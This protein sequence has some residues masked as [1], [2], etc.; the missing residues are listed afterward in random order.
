MEKAGL[1]KAL[2][3]QPAPAA[4]VAELWETPKLRALFAAVPG[5][6][7]WVM[8]QQME[9]TAIA[10][11]TGLE[12]LR[13]EWMLRQFQ[14]LGLQA[15]VDE[16]GN[17]VAERAGARRGEPV[18]AVTAHLD[19]AFAP[20]TA[21]TVERRRGRVWAPGI[22]DNGAG[23]A[24]LL[25]MARLLR[26][27]HC[28]PRRGL[29]L[30][31][32]VGEEGEGDLRGMRHL[33]APGS[34]LGRRI[35]A[36]VVLDGPGD[37]QITTGALPSRRLRVVFTG[38]GGHSWSD[39]GRASATH[40]AV[41]AAGALLAQVHPRPGVLGC[42]IGVLQGGTVVNAI[43]AGAE[44]KLDLRAR[45]REGLEELGQAVRRAVASGLEQERAAALRGAVRARIE[46]LGERPGGALAAGS[47]L[48]ELVR[49][50]DAR[51]GIRS[52]QQFASTDAN[53][54]IAQGRDALRLGAGGSGGGI[55]TLGEWF[56][57]E[58][59]ARA[60]QRLLLIVLAWC[61]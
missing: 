37:D 17:V 2:A 1:S 16:A 12:G 48:L 11:P 9:V 27:A 60:L 25:A 31:A 32:T 19:T 7:A 45:S 52:R 26:D 58:G 42:N 54:P 4:E 6:E 38:P 40:A 39:L 3:V 29:L 43:A 22:A 57:P 28:R 55:H 34:K 18:L 5:L 35:G 44:L 41:R 8:R 24:A 23:L 15:G 30:V 33:F 56:E 13:A 53:I 20:G 51:L 49:Q 14:A 10:A 36:T 59:R 50:A 46:P 61:G 47:P 21:V